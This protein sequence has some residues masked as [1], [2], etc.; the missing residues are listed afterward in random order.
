MKEPPVQALS[1]LLACTFTRST[2]YGREGLTTPNLSLRLL[3]TERPVAMQVLPHLPT[4]HDR[5][6]RAETP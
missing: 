3:V 2:A 5:I 6:A 4:R 1:H